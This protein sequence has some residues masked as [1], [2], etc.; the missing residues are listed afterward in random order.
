MKRSHCF[1]ALS[2]CALLST[3]DWAHAH[4][5]AALGRQGKVD[6][7]NAALEELLQ[8]KPGFS[9]TYA[10]N[11]LFYIESGEQVE[12]YIDALRHAGVP[13]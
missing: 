12:E 4:L 11:H 2:V 6:E 8:M 10:R 13:E 9:C 1:I 7:A 5:A 3:A